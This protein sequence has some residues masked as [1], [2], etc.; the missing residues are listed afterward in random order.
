M[1][2]VF[3]GGTMNKRPEL[4]WIHDYLIFKWDYLDIVSVYINEENFIS[5]CWELFW[6]EPFDIDKI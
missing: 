5:R 4:S 2:E 1:L 3:F 6:E